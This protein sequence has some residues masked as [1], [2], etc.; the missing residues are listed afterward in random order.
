[1]THL[2]FPQDFTQACGRISLVGAGPG[3][4]D[5][6]TIR[7]LKRL[8]EADIVFFDRLID[9][10]VL[11]LIPTSAE[12]V[13]V[14]KEVGRCKWP[15]DRIDAA[16]VM[17]ALA[18][19]RVVRL[20]SGDPSIFGRAAEEI[21][22]AQLHGIPVDIIP[23]VTAASAAAASTLCPLTER[24]KF[25]RLLMLTATAMTGELPE[26]F[27]RSIAPGTRLAIYMGIHLAA[28]LRSRLIA[29]GVSDKAPVTL[30][31]NVAKAGE[32]HV[33]CTLDTLVSTIADQQIRNP[34]VIFVDVERVACRAGKS[35]ASNTELSAY[36]L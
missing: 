13:N 34:A 24:G 35:D 3:A 31:Q 14:G 27:A 33:E 10:E 2:P 19:K 26:D 20:K 7:A 32:R 15:Q 25:D 4:A 28:Q 23:G 36:A 1:M 12:Q 9:P 8:Q 17:A 29:A 6:L 16:I 11:A 22:A 21:A 5:L 18:G 30:A